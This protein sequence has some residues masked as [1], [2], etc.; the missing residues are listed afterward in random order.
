MLKGKKFP[1][2]VIN[3]KKCVTGQNVVIGEQ[4]E[5]SEVYGAEQLLSESLS[6]SLFKAHI[7]I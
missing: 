5:M 3:G 6:S 4:N 7:Y 1:Y 2:T